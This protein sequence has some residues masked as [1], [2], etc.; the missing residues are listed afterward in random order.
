M[1][2]SYRTFQKF[3]GHPHQRTKLLKF[4]DGKIDPKELDK[5]T[6]GELMS[7]AYNTKIKGLK[8]LL[9]NHLK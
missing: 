4:V 9:I 2:T 8:Q 1:A 7:V 6:I 5:L 3:Q